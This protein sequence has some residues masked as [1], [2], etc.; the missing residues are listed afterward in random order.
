M[1]SL[2]EIRNKKGLCFNC[3]EVL[4]GVGF[5]SRRYE[6]KRYQDGE[7]YPESFI[8]FCEKCF[9]EIAGPTFEIQNTESINNSPPTATLKKSIPL[10]T[11]CDVCHT[12][13]ARTAKLKGTDYYLCSN[14]CL[15]TKQQQLDDIAKVKLIQQFCI[16][17]L[18]VISIMCIAVSVITIWRYLH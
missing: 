5:G 9:S 7:S 10:P 12:Q 11:R 17:L 1:I 4:C 3:K 13:T 2:Q 6:I 15:I 16:F 14:K 18:A 8:C